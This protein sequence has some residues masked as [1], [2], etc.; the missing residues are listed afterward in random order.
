[1]SKRKNQNDPYE[2]ADMGWGLIIFLWICWWPLGVGFTI[3]KLIHQQK[4]QQARDAERARR[5][6]GQ[7]APQRP[8]PGQYNY[9]PADARQDRD[10]EGT[11]RAQGSG[12]HPTFAQTEAP[13]ARTR[14]SVDIPSSEQTKAAGKRSWLT[15]L[16]L[17]LGTLLMIGGVGIAVDGFDYLMWGLREYGELLTHAIT[18]DILPGLLTAA[19][20]G[21]MF[22]TGLR[23]R[24][25]AKQEK[26]LDTI[27]GPR[28]HVT[29]DELSAASGLGKK[30]VLKVVQSAIAHGLQGDFPV[31]TTRILLLKIT[32]SPNTRRNS[33]AACITADGCIYLFDK[34]MILAF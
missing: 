24:K 27:V 7:Y 28:D 31:C 26:L 15:P 3:G 6:A 4:R 8:A 17:V 16:L 19:G 14:S 2:L 1:M 21:A 9:R 34:K 23:N 10:Y 32:T 25:M 33:T 22:G 5:A 13:A 12:D 30:E 11:L 29:L 20:G 18:G